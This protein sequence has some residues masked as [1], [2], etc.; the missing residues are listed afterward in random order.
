MH[1]SRMRTVRCSGRLWGG[2]L[3]G[4][5]GCLLWGMYT[6][7][8]KIWDRCKNITF[9]QLHLRTVTRQHARIATACW[10]PYVVYTGGGSLYGEVQCIMGNGHMG[11]S[12]PFGQTDRQTRMK[13]LPLPHI[14]YMITVFQ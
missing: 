7:L 6:P 1:S 2:C 10:Q 3:P 14:Y 8:K 11:H 9:P 12:T 13:T 4:G 5:G